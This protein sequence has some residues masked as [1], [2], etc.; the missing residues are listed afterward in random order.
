M[1]DVDLKVKAIEDLDEKVIGTVLAGI[2]RFGDYRVMVLPDHATPVSTKTHAA[3]PVPFLIYDSRSSSGS[4]RAYNEREAA[5]TG[6]L[7]DEGHLL[8]GQFL[9]S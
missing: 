4:G 7:I 3:D 9:A 5:A 6:E 1:G 2:D 8:I